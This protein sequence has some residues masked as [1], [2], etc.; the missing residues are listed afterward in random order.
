MHRTVLL[1]TLPTHPTDNKDD[2]LDRSPAIISLQKTHFSIE[3]AFP[4]SRALEAI[5]SF[6]LIE[7]NDIVSELS[8]VF[9]SYRRL[10]ILLV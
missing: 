8:L 6:Q 2:H 3:S 1:G 10:D 4:V 9:I 5:S 7:Q